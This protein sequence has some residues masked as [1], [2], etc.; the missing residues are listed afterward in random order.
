MDWHGPK[1][2]GFEQGEQCVLSIEEQHSRS[3]SS[4]DFSAQPP[5]APES[6][7]LSDT[8]EGKENKRDRILRGKSSAHGQKN[9]STGYSM[10]EC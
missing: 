1:N 3:K 10:K 7:Q 5:E 6:N 4:P 9:S 8:I 2:G